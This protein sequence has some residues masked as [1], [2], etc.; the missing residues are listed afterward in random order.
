MN[1]EKQ[2]VGDVTLLT[3]FGE[4]DAAADAAQLEEIDELIG[5][6]TH[7]I[8]NFHG[9]TFVNS[10]ALGYL[11]KTSKT[12]RDRGGELIFSEAAKPFRN[13]V[14]IYGVGPVFAMY[15]NDQA[16]LDHFQ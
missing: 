9:L 12:L 11:L 16:A 8:F 3:F 13:I 7:V 14:E 15:A 6:C 2:T 10:S 5:D 1:I 4:F